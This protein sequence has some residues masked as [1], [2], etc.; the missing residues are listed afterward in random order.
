M[1][2]QQYRIAGVLFEEEHERLAVRPSLGYNFWQF[3]P[4]TIGIWSV[5]WFV[6]QVN[7][8]PAWSANPDVGGRPLSAA[9]YAVSLAAL[10]A[11]GAIASTLR[12]GRAHVFDKGTAVFR[13]G[14]RPTPLRS[15]GPT[16]ACMCATPR[17]ACIEVNP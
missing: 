1:Q 10:A 8:S 14:L 3:L 9:F 17:S 4:T 6:V 2:Q 16:T 15:R 7:S 5:G 11:A 12:L 13:R